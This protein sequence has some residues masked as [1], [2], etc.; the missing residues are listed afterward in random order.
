[1]RI[2]S[3]QYVY[4]ES[5][6]QE[7]NLLNDS[8]F[9][10]VVKDEGACEDLIR[11]IMSDQTIKVKSVITQK[12]LNSINERGVRLDALCELED[13]KLVNIE[14]QKSDNTNHFKRARYNIGRIDVENTDKGVDF[15]DL[16]DVW[17]I[18]IMADDFIKSGEAI[19]E[20][21]RI[22]STNGQLADNGTR[23]IYVNCSSKSI[24]DA[25]DIKML[26]NYIKDTKRPLFHCKRLVDRVNLCKS[27][28]R[29]S[30][31]SMDIVE[32][33]SRIG[34]VVMSA[35]LIRDGISNIELLSKNSKIPMYE[36]RYVESL[37][38]EGKT[39]NEI[40]YEFTE[41]YNDKNMYHS[42]FGDTAT[43]CPNCGA[44]LVLLSTGCMCS[45]C[46]YSR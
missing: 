5:E 18:Y 14:M 32:R 17:V 45:K 23:E 34:R 40:D 36:L 42:V 46:N 2:E 13:G 9:E 10:N 26:I 3:N 11:A 33:E 31:V 16:K 28:E 25:P 38:R 29:R 7:L 35:G 37:V 43:K 27:K 19:C 20:V 22:L 21:N 12:T 30:T 41:L 8:L 15:K 24:N 4:K 44:D 6:I 1:M 39:D